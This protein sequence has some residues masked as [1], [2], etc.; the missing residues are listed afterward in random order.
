MGFI[1]FSFTTTS[2][3][4]K[5]IPIVGDVAGNILD[6]SEGTEA[7]QV[8]KKDMPSTL[9]KIGILAVLLY[10]AMSGK[11]SWE[12]AEHGKEFIG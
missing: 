8:N 2:A 5:S 6:E 9:I 1:F 12:D 11:I 3:I 10:L 7:G 4:L